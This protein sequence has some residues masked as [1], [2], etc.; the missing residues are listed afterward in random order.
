[1]ACCSHG[2]CLS[3]HNILLF[4][5]LLFWAL[6]LLS[7]VTSVVCGLWRQTLYEWLAVVAAVAYVM[8]FTVLFQIDPVD[9][10]LAAFF[11]CRRR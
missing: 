3:R 10:E 11:C 4:L 7:L 9:D 8:L 6:A 5:K 2:Y 1:M